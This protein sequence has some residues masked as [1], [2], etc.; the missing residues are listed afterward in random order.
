MSSSNVFVF[1][2][3]AFPGLESTSIPAYT[4]P[5]LSNTEYEF[6]STTFSSKLFCPSGVPSSSIIA[7]T[8]SLDSSNCIYIAFCFCASILEFVSII[9]FVYFELLYVVSLV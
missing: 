9:I 1:S 6:I 7:L 3:S 5:S 2:G 8:A 4:F